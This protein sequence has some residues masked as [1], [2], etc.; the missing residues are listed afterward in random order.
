MFIFFTPYTYLFLSLYFIILTFMFSINNF[1]IY[2]LFI[3]IV[4][5]L[6]IGVS[7][8]IF[9]HS[10]TQLMLYFLFQT[11]ASFSVIVFYLLTYKY[12]LF[13]RLFLKL[14][15]FPFFSWYINVLYRF[16]SFILFLS[17][18]L[19][20]LPPI[21][22]FYMMFEYQ[23]I[24]FI[25]LF[26]VL[27]VI[28]SSIYMLYVKDLRYLVIISSV[29]NNSFMLLAILSN[30][31]LVFLLFYTVYMVNTY[32]ILY[33]FGNLSSHT[34]SYKLSYSIFI[35]AL[36]LLLLNLGSFPPFPGFFSK[37]LVF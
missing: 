20:K 5:L 7:Y 31:V 9:I 11:L 19:H 37:F 27:T 12:L 29:G 15:M 1:F 33:R 36:F 2:W 32:L 24:A 13:I 14:G 8:T 4:M 18:T 34:M 35:L 22:I 6:F 25:L 17:S 3:E 23:Y 21:Y 26:C 10:Y 28:I 16:P 30:S